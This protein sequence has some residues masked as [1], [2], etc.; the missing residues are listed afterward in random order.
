MKGKYTA[1]SKSFWY[2]K[3]SHV[4]T[5]TMFNILCLPSPHAGFF[6]GS[7]QG[8]DA[9]LRHKM[10][11]ISPS[12]LKKYGIPF[13]RVSDRSSILLRHHEKI[14]YLCSD[15][16]SVIVGSFYY[17]SSPQPV[18][19]EW[20]VIMKKRPL[21]TFIYMGWHSVT[22]NAMFFPPSPQLTQVSNTP[23]EKKQFI[24]PRPRWTII[25]LCQVNFIYHC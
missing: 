19:V 10:T 8:C 22:H 17:I 16:M 3:T 18:L 2:L 14:G 25:Y 12:I 13:D 7:S 11:L 4:W 24:S 6:P 21:H 20:H 1:L 15:I 5:W 23:M 9:F